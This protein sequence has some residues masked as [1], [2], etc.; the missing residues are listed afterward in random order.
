MRAAIGAVRDPELDRTLDELGTLDE[1]TVGRRGR[2][3]IQVALVADDQAAALAAA[4][5]RAAQDAGGTRVDVD[6]VPLPPQR[7]A[8]LAARLAG[9]TGR[10]AGPAPRI[11]A[12]ASGKG[13]VGKST[14]TAN[15]AA[16]LAATGQRVGLLDADVWGY[17]V[18]QLF[19]VHRP[20]VV[21]GGKMQPIPAHGVSLMSTGF[22][23]DEDD[24]VVWRG[25]MLHKALSQFVTDVA[26]GPLDVLFVDLPP[27]TGDATLSV[28]ELL[29]DAA[30]LAVTTPQ[31]AAR[32]VARRVIRM[33]ADTGAPIAGVVENMADAV[34]GTCGDTTAV[35][36]TGGGE[37][38][39]AE[40]GT[41]LLGRVPLDL[42]LREAADRGV[43]VV[44]DTPA[45]ISARELL[46]IAEL[47]PATRRPL[48]RRSLPLAVV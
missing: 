7:R 26:W 39:A 28:L 1:V 29:P 13:G 43:P 4:V 17:S 47:L 19:G 46:R 9:D 20:P 35:F 45:A 15:L 27:G 48:V 22:F 33:A 34:C 6:T 10:S 3:Q 5:R 12:V 18:P 2:V 42:A 44:R 40:A 23:V 36:G 21:L 38:L 14:V 31:T 24:P 25:P 32:V 11:Y 8:E 16:A 41:T 30:L 37:A